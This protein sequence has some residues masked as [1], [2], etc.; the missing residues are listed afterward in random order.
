MLIAIRILALGGL[1]LSIISLV[2]YIRMRLGINEGASFCNISAQFNCDLVNRSRW[3][4]FFGIPL[5]SYGGAFYLFI[6]LL[7]F[8]KHRAF[9]AG[10]SFV[11]TAVSAI[12]SIFLFFVSKYEIGTFCLL[13]IGM[14]IV[15]ILLFLAAIMLWRDRHDKPRGEEVSF[16]RQIFPLLFMILAALLYLISSTNVVYSILSSGDSA[17]LRNWRS[18]PVMAFR[19]EDKSVISRDFTSGPADA[20]IQVLEFSDLEC[21]ACRRFAEILKEVSADYPEKVKVVFKNYPLDKTCNP[22]LRSDMHLNACFAAEFARC[23]GEQGKFWQ[24]VEYIFAVDPEKRLENRNYIRQELESSYETLALDRE[25]IGEC[26]RSGRQMSKIKSDIKEGDKLGIAGTPA[27][28]I[29]GKRAA[30]LGEEVLRSIFD[31]ILGKK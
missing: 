3:A 13:C 15:N 26:L 12:F 2:H 20:P 31:D 5:A 24:A 23:A 17:F 10:L 6:F 29:N 7:S 19:I 28:W 16:G 22:A 4:A 9:K 27:V 21:G 1:A 25:A 14:Y 18:E 8:L 11:L 30:H